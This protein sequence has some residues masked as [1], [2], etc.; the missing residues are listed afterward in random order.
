MMLVS[1]NKLANDKKGYKE[2]LSAVSEELRDALVLKSGG[3]RS[4]TVSQKLAKNWP[5]LLQ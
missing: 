4:I 5:L 2:F 1:L 3:T